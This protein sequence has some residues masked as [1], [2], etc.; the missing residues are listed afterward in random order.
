M[1]WSRVLLINIVVIVVIAAIGAGLYYYF[2]QSWNYVSTSDAQVSGT[3]VPVAATTGGKLEDWKGTVG[4][5]FSQGD[6]IGDL[7]GM[8][9]TGDITAPITGTIVQNNVVN[10]QLVGAG[11]PIAEMVDMNH[12]Y[13]VA[14]IDE[15]QIKNV[16]VGADVDVSVDADPGDTID[17]K[18]T[19]IGL[20]T[21][22]VFSL[23]PEQN[24]SGDYTKV[25]QR[26]PV[27]I[28]MPNGYSN[29]L[30]PGMNASVKIHR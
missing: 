11:L 20:A 22:S 23:I 14:N 17:G 21:N 5:S 28:S 13:I 12:L 25:V 27:E 10:G 18:V 19:Q 6:T 16:K 9:A 8:G 26:I 7:A 2:Y 1:K 24:A 29:V 15:T 30:V 4:A 3:L